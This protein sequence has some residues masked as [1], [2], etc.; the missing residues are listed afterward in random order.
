MQMMDNTAEH[1]LLVRNMA[2]SGQQHGGPHPVKAPERV[3]GP[4]D[5]L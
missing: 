1:S 5:P 2:E 4:I 3:I